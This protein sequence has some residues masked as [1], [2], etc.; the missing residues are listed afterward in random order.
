M[1]ALARIARDASALPLAGGCVTVTDNIDKEMM[2]TTLTAIERTARD[3][4]LHALALDDR[5][6]AQ[7]AVAYDLGDG[8]AHVAYTDAPAIAAPVADCAVA[9]AGVIVRSIA[10]YEQYVINRAETAR[11]QTISPT[12]PHATLS[13]P[14]TMV[15]VETVDTAPVADGGAAS[16]VIK[17]LDDADDDKMEW[18]GAFVSGGAKVID[19]DNYDTPSSSREKRLSRLRKGGDDTSPKADRAGGVN[20]D[21]LARKLSKMSP[22]RR[23]VWAWLETM[24]VT[25]DEPS[26][27]DAAAATGISHQTS[28]KVLKEY[29]NTYGLYRG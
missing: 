15:D 1:T 7:Y 11:A 16:G 2:M 3:A 10:G 17:G 26:C 20:P 29:R 9:L 27:Y 25:H 19:P 5:G 24:N 6:R 21:D 13:A 22:Q 14:E 4:S 23:K 12:M 28:N 18:L 8:R